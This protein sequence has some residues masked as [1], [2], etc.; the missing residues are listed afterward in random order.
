MLTEAGFKDA[1]H[2]RIGPTP[3]SAVLGTAA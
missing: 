1:S 3:N 2:V